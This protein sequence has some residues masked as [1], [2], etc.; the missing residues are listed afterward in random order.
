VIDEVKAGF[1]RTGQLFAFQHSRALPDAVMLGKPMAS[2]I[3]LSAVVGRA[4]I[5][6]AVPSGHMMTT[7][8]NPVACAVGLA[9][10]TVIQQEGLVK[11]AAKY[12]ARLKEG[13]QMLAERYPQIGDVRGRGLMIGVELIVPETVAPNPALVAQLCFRAKELGLILFYVGT[14]S[15]VIEITPPLIVDKEEIARGI[16]LFEQALAD[17]LA[18]KVSSADLAPYLGW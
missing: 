11:R 1:G 7:A 12:G 17:A 4:E 10:L 14:F 3:P 9:T 8:G 15:N 18:G 16:E 2:G 13:L 6:D 5:L